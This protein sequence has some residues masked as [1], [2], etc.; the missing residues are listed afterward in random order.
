MKPEQSNKLD[1][2]IIRKEFDVEADIGPIRFC[3]NLAKLEGG[4][5][6]MEF[7][8]ELQEPTQ[9]DSLLQFPLK[10]ER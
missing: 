8:R 3:W 2:V 5:L 4:I 1:E 10:K 9:K 7:W 6:V